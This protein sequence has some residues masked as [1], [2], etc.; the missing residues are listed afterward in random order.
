VAGLIFFSFFL[1]ARVAKK[2]NTDSAG[3]RLR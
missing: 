3:T 1:V 2:H